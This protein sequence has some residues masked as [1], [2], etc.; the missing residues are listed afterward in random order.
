MRSFACQNLLYL[1]LSIL[2]E[3]LIKTNKWT[4]KQVIVAFWIN[5]L[6]NPALIKPFGNLLGVSPSIPFVPLCRAVWTLA[7]SLGDLNTFSW[8]VATCYSGTSTKPD[9]QFWWVWAYIS[10]DPKDYNF[11]MLL[12]IVFHF[13]L[14]MSIELFNL[15]H[16]KKSTRWKKINWH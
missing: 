15:K 9:F 14:L 10:P 8:W 6:F 4:C 1:Q 2:L 3:F 11:I 7:E 13:K 5:Y 16:R 12:R